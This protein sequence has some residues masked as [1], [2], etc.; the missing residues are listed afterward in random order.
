MPFLDSVTVEVIEGRDLPGSIAISVGGKR[1]TTKDIDE[2]NACWV[3]E[4]VFPACGEEEILFESY[5]VSGECTGSALLSLSELALEPG[6]A[7]ETWLPLSGNDETVG[8]VLVRVEGIFGVQDSASQEV[9]LVFLS[10]E[11]LPLCDPY[12]VGTVGESSFQ[13]T[14]KFSTSN[15]VW[16]ECFALD[17]GLDDTLLIV[18][19]SEA[20]EVG[21]VILRGTDVMAGLGTDVWLPLKDASDRDAGRLLVAVNDKYSGAQVPT[22]GIPLPLIVKAVCVEQLPEI[23]EPYVE[24]SYYGNK[25]RTT[26]KAPEPNG[27]II[28]DEEFRFDVDPDGL[29]VASIC[30]GVEELVGEADIPVQALKQVAENGKHLEVELFHG[31]TPS[32]ILVLAATEGTVQYE[33][34]ADAKEDLVEELQPVSSSG[35]KKLAVT[36]EVAQVE[37]LPEEA[38]GKGLAV[39]C[40]LGDSKQATT[41]RPSADPTW[42]EFVQFLD[43]SPDDTLAVTLNADGELLGEGFVPVATLEEAAAGG[44]GRYLEVSLTRG[45]EALSVV[46]VLGAKIAVMSEAPATV[47]RITTAPAEYSQ[48]VLVGAAPVITRTTLADQGITTYSPADLSIPVERNVTRHTLDGGV[49]VITRGLEAEVVEVAGGKV[50]AMQVTEIITRPVATG[51][52]LTSTQ[53][54][55][56]VPVKITRM[57]LDGQPLGAA[58]VEVAGVPP[59]ARIEVPGVVEEVRAGY[60]R[61]PYAEPVILPD[62]PA[63][64]FVG[65]VEYNPQ[66]AAFSYSPMQSYSRACSPLPEAYGYTATAYSYE[67]TPAI[68][69]SVVQSGYPLHR[70]TGYSSHLASYP[71]HS[72]PHFTTREYYEPAPQFAT[73]EYYETPGTM[74]PTA[75]YPL[76]K[77]AKKSQSAT[78]PAWNA[79]TASSKSKTKKH[80]TKKPS[81]KASKKRATTRPISTSARPTTVS[82]PVVSMASSGIGFRPARMMGASPAAYSMQPTET[83]YLSLSGHLDGKYYGGRI[84]DV[85]TNEWFE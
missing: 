50:P 78:T 55:D 10:A 77:T 82:G 47:A 29:I 75:G 33:R 25:K 39:T 60:I 54:L 63:R 71:G 35:T 56:G 8:E 9:E 17:L 15:P 66:S 44:A 23:D 26:T 67:P 48:P 57:Q 61:P 24:L 38:E 30:S 84:L 83:S 37:C 36:I 81:S 1:E 69:S 13:T 14:T 70:Q 11:G 68:S 21:S 22:K 52:M 62:G 80:S 43:I 4:F 27:D 6:S 59:P 2:P 12:V 28:F 41:T 74:G 5:S 64:E 49:R 16:E 73:R 51:P 72:M 19:K 46:L 20:D 34:K 7:M 32:G 58:P 31:D 40:E 85:S 76:R 42:N 45:A 3:E 79:G 65:S 18:V 53:T